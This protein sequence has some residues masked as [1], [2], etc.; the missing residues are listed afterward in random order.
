MN[1]VIGS[2][3]VLYYHDESLGTDIPFACAT[4]CA[5]DVQTNMKEVTNQLSAWYQQFKVDTSS[6]SISCDGLI[7][8]D[9]YSYL[10]M[11]QM[12]QNRTQIL[13]KF[14]IDNGTAGGL[15]II[16]GSANLASLTINGPYDAL[17]TYS[18][19]LQGTGGYSTTGTQ[20]TPGGIVISGTN[21]IVLQWAANGGETYHTFPTGIATTLIYGSRGGTT[22][23]PI[24]YAGSPVSP[25]GCVWNVSTGTLT[26]PS[27]NPFVDGELVIILVE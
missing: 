4:S 25:N 20:V 10:Y 15:V 1:A 13:I 19:K 27:D 6:W 3:I 23:A 7:I 9:N 12:Q 24:I 8:L 5:F 16:N 21:V 22:F 26:V 14:V 17:G 2:N 18:A 11:L